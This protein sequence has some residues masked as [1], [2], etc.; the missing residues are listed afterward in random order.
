MIIWVIECIESEDVK[1][2]LL[3]SWLLLSLFFILNTYICNIY[4]YYCYDTI[5][6]VSI[7][8]VCNNWLHII[9]IIILV[10]Y[11]LYINCSLIIFI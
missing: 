6:I 7:S 10:S 1:M 8:I 5:I 3:L 11:Y 2:G 4:Y 9:I